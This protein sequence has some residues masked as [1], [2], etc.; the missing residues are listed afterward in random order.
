MCI[1]DS[2][3]L[4]LGCQKDDQSPITNSTLPPIKIQTEACFNPH[5]RTLVLAHPDDNYYYE[6]EKQYKVEWFKANEFLKQGTRLSC[7][8][9]GLYQSKITFLQF[10]SI[11]SKSYEFANSSKPK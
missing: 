3:I 4:F 7:V 8:G 6:D 9:P 5:C 10:D 1:R 11:Q 2:V